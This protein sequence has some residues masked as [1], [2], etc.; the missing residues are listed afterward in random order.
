MLP[1]LNKY[2]AR[3]KRNMLPELNKYVARIKKYV[4]RIK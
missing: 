2:V 3:I 1:K 4:A